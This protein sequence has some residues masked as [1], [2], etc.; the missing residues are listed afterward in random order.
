[1]SD[2]PYHPRRLLLG[3]WAKVE[4]LVS[5]LGAVALIHY[6]TSSDLILKRDERFHVFRLP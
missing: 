6:E 3:D 4:E 2:A 1:M 5:G